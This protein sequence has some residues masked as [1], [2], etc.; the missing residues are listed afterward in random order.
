MK[1]NE[2]EQSKKASIRS[3]EVNM[4]LRLV[5]PS[6]KH[7]A[8]IRSDKSIILHITVNPFLNIV[9]FGCLSSSVTG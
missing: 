2:A 6:R 3:A 9:T 8:Q 1:P 4:K 7:Y 5:T